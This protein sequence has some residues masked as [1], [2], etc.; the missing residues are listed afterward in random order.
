M[1]TIGPELSSM[2]DFGI[3]PIAKQKLRYPIENCIH[4]LSGVCTPIK[5]IPVR[6]MKMKKFP[7]FF[8]LLTSPVKKSK[9]LIYQ[10]YSY[11]CD[12]S[13]TR[14]NSQYALKSCRYME[15]K[16]GMISQNY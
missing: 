7:E 3:Q 14:Q 2:V 16:F 4:C 15:A 6:P 9:S 8:M 5:I 13:L 11:R 1:Q 12:V 10:K